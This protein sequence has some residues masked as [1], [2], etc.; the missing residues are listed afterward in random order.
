VLPVAAPALLARHPAL[1]RPA[2][3]A[4][5]PLLRT[6][7]E[8]WTPWF[9]AAGLDWPE[10]D[11]GP[12]LVDLGMTLEAALAAQGVALA[13]PTLAAPWLAGGS[14]K[15]LF[16]PRAPPARQY[17]VRHASHADAAAFSLWLAGHC[18]RRAREAL[19][20]LSGLT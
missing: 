16:G 7:I 8:P 6:P 18:E 3:L 12:L 2:D 9:R 11:G 1:Q 14:L 5:L 20:L 19:A 15:P 4:R 13:R 17:L 10:P